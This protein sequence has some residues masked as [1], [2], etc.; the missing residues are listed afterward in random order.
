MSDQ[1][2]AQ[3]QLSENVHHDLHRG[4]VCDGKGA[5]VQDG[6]QLEGS[7]AVG[8]QGGSVLGEV[9]PGV[10]HDALLFAPSVFCRQKQTNIL[11]RSFISHYR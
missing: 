6:A 11:R 10:Q 9:H 2:L 8:R 5:H 7:G 1:T 3:P 4:V